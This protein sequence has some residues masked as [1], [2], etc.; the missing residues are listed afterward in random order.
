MASQLEKYYNDKFS[1][2]VNPKDGFAVAECM[3]ARARRVLEFLISIFMYLKKPTLV[4]IIV[5]YIIF[6][7]LSKEKKVDWALV[8]RDVVKR[9]LARV[10]KSKPIPIYPYIFHL[11]HYVEM[12]KPEDMKVYKIGEAILK[13]NVNLNPELEPTGKEDFE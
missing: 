3:D 13:H 1:N 9:L 11:Y 7:A 5:G 2:L 10:A 8:I 12:M 6:G 4:T